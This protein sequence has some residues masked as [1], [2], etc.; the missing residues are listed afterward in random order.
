M[1]ANENGY[2]Q[3]AGYSHLFPLLRVLLHL[4]L[5]ASVAQDVRTAG[6]QALASVLLRCFP[7]CAQEG[8]ELD[9]AVVEMDT[10]PLEALKACR[11]R[12]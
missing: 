1:D 8:S 10:V 4:S 7:S 9:K 11:M 12:S 2:V 6:M 3:E 5:A